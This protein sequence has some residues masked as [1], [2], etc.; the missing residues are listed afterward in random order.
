MNKYYIRRTGK[1]WTVYCNTSH[2]FTMSC[3][4]FWTK[5]EAQRFVAEV[6]S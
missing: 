5:D 1:H 4:T 6:L 3:G 2:G